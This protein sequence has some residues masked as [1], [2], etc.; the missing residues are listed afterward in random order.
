MVGAGRP[1]QRHLSEPLDRSV[2]WLGD[3][4]IRPTPARTTASANASVSSPGADAPRLTHVVEAIH[5][6]TSAGARPASI[7]SPPT[8]THAGRPLS[9]P[10]TADREMPD[11]IRNEALPKCGSCGVRFQQGSEIPVRFYWDDLPS[12]RVRPD[13]TREQALELAQAFARDGL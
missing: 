5:A 2:E 3:G 1:N 11:R 13:I 8:A 4:R 6:S 10:A 9:A 12:R 7:T